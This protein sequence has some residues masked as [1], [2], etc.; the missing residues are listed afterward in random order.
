MTTIAIKEKTRKLLLKIAADLQREKGERVNFDTV[1]SYLINLY[2]TQQVDLE[3]WRSFTEPIPG[4]TFEDMY[5]ELITER[6]LD[7]VR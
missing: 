5:S 6:R 4:V 2:E 1:V 3:T 7:D